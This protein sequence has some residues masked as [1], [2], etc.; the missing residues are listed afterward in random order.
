MKQEFSILREAHL[1]RVLLTR[2]LDSYLNEVETSF[3]SLFQEVVEDGVL[4]PWNSFDLID[5]FG[6]MITLRSVVFQETVEVRMTIL[7]TVP[8]SN[9]SHCDA[10][11]SFSCSLSSNSFIGGDNYYSFLARFTAANNG[12]PFFR[13]WSPAMFIA[14]CISAGV[15]G[16]EHN[17]RIELDVLKSELSAGGSTNILLDREV[18]DLLPAVADR[19]LAALIKVGN[20]ISPS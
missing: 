13:D 10:S 18:L 7:A 2:G 5:T 11:I 14:L 17:S 9:S 12:V 16:I 6:H 4:Y 1:T 8:Q 19:M 3:E 20:V 15:L